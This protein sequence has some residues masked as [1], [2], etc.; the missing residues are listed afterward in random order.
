[1]KWIECDG[2]GAE[3][4]VVCDL[5]DSVE[6]C[7]FCGESIDTEEEEEDEYEDE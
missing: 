1:M 3:F 5:V 4:R 7:P 2:C 6:Y